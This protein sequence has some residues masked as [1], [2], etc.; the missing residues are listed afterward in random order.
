MVELQRKL[1]GLAFPGE[2]ATGVEKLLRTFA[3]IHHQVEFANRKRSACLGRS[4]NAIKKNATEGNAFRN[5]PT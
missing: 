2:S 3:D 4:T 5:T 1:H